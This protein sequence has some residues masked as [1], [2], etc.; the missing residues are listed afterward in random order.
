MSRQ[1]DEYYF[2]SGE[3]MKDQLE[4]FVP[5]ND[6]PNYMICEEGYVLSPVGKI[7]K[8]DIG[9]REG[10]LRIRFGKKCEYLHRLLAKQFLSNPNNYPIVR[11]LDDNVENNRLDNLAWGTQK[12]NIHDSMRNRTYT[13]FT[14]EM[15]EKSYE[16]SR[17]PVI[18][19]NLK[20]GEE[21]YF[22]GQN[23][24]CRSLGVQQ[25]NLFKVLKGERL[26][27]CGYSFRYAKK[28]GMNNE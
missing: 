9:D 1:F 4:K 20:T 15:R 3:Y 13:G 18:A 27:T 26:Q 19:T 25:S 14:D 12:D 6:Y 7:K 17:T 28:G 21:L 22:K 8:P 16:K 24:A 23:D 5:I 11:H 10:H 2:D